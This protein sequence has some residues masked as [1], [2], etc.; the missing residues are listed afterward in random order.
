MTSYPV[1]TPPYSWHGLTSQHSKL[2]FERCLPQPAPPE[3]SDPMKFSTI[4]FVLL[5]AGALY[6]WTGG[7]MLIG[8]ST[9]G[10]LPETIAPPNATF[11]GNEQANPFFGQ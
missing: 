3:S 7:E 8:L 2:R 11:M 6:Y 10:D 4:V 1:L 9:T 5:A